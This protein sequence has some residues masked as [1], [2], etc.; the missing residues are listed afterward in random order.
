[1]VD[2][3]LDALA[4]LRRGTH[5]LHQRL[6]SAPL[7]ARLSAA[8]LTRDDYICVLVALQHLYA[9]LETG[10]IHSLRQHTPDYRYTP[11]LPLLQRD[12]A[13]LGGA[14][15][16]NPDLPPASVAGLAATLGMLYVIEG[17]ALGGKLLRERLQ[18]R[19]GAAVGGALAFYGLEGDWPATQTLLRGSLTPDDIDQAVMAARQTF[20]LFIRS[21]EDALA[22]VR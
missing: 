1:M 4:A 5:D 14:A 19:L 2:N 22:Q 10:L 16:L 9:G 12:L 3:R 8:D 6:E 11:R 18:S 13:Q 15:A 20:L 7:F 17:S 21:G